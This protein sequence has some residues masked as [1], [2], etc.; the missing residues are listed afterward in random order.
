MK[1]KK[2]GPS[3][4]TPVSAYVAQYNRPYCLGIFLKLEECLKFH[5]KYLY[6]SDNFVLVYLAKSSVNKTLGGYLKYLS[7]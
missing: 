6:V 5:Q 2:F 4:S 3:A 7:Y 1:V